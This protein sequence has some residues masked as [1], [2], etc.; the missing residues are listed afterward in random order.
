MAR[1]KRGISSHAK[2][3]KVLKSTKGYRMTKSRNIRVAKEA[4]L[5]AGEYA[6]VGRKLKKRDM[7]EIWV[8]RINQAIQGMDLNYS[9]FIHALKKSNI[10]LDRKIL[11]DL[12]INDPNVFRIIV[13]KAKEQL[14]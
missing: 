13:D 5:H 10:E 8:S 3:K 4:S 6:F 14:N 12:V 1:V 9:K 11:A 2:H 7:R